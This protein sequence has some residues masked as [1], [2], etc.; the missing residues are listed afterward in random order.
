MSS[1]TPTMEC[2]EREENEIVPVSSKGKGTT[3]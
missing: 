1:G 3:A 2:I